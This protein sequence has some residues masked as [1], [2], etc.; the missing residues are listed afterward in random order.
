M[1]KHKVLSRFSSKRDKPTTRLDIQKYIWVAQ[2]NEIKE[3][4][5]RQG[6]YGDGIKSWEQE[7]LI[8]RIENGKYILTQDGKR[9]VKNPKS[10]RQIN[11]DREYKRM[12]LMVKALASENKKLRNKIQYI[13]DV[14][15][16]DI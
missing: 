12:K 5:R 7:G 11:K 2:G 14:L 3:F 16:N 6:Y 8:E 15:F 10:M 4:K 13:Y 9:Y 1:I